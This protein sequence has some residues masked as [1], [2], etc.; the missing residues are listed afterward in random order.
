MHVA[1][2]NNHAEYKH[3][4][5]T[6]VMAARGLTRELDEAVG[7]GGLWPNQLASFVQEAL[8]LFRQ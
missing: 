7:D 8:V 3:T 4:E 6:L 5:A 1:M 2:N